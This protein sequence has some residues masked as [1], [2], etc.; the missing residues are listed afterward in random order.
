MRRNR[1]SPVIV[2]GAPLG[3]PTGKDLYADPEA[4]LRSM[5]RG[6]D[7][8]YDD[9]EPMES[10]WHLNQM[11]LLID[12]LKTHW[13]DRDDFFCGGNMFLYFS[14]R[15]EFNRDFRGPDFFVVKGVDRYR[16]R[17]SWI[18]WE[19]GGRLPNVIIE[20]LSE[21]TRKID[22]G[23]KK[24]LYSTI[25]RTPEYFCYDPATDVIEGWRIQ[26][27]NSYQPV[28]AEPN[29]RISSKELELELGRWD[30]T[31]RDN[32]ARWLRFFTRDG[33]L[34]LTRDE[35][36]EGKARDAEGKARDAEGKARDAEKLARAEA[37]ARKAAE[38][39]LERLKRQLAARKKKK[40]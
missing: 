3:L 22:R 23:E 4:A 15:Q 27:G 21:P 40:S 25:F 36:A 34:V 17:V 24:V 28:P 33:N 16:D 2:R 1:Y 29:G 8:P 19:E 32:R 11:V 13:Y 35:V 12:S 30:G 9:G 7:L 6:R 10:P 31:I 5:P 26:Q 37:K 39:E 20:L 38:A 14:D 18:A